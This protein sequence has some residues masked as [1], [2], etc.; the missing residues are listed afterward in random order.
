MALACFISYMFLVEFVDVFMT[1]G[2]WFMAHDFCVLRFLHV[3]VELVDLLMT[4]DSSLTPPHPES[5]T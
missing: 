3:L 2:S 5:H 4:H 1:H